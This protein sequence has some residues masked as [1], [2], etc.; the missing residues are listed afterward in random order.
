MSYDFNQGKVVE[1]PF[2]ARFTMENTNDMGEPLAPQAALVM[3]TEFWKFMYLV[4]LKLIQMKRNNQLD[5]KK[6]QKED[7]IDCY[8]SPYCAPPYIDL[9]WRLLI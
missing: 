4:F 9:A 8:P 5:P 7:G 1:L 2:E 6:I 3:I